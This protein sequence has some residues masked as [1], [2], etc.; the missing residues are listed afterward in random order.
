MIF[1]IMKIRTLPIFSLCVLL[2]IPAALPCPASSASTASLETA[3]TL[4]LKGDVVKAIS[5]FQQLPESEE[6]SYW[7]VRAYLNQGQAEKAVTE[8]QK[9]LENNTG[10]A[11]TCSAMGDVEFRQGHFESATEFYRQ[12]IESGQE[13]ARSYLGLGKIL[14]SEKMLKSAKECFEKAFSLDPE[15]PDII[16]EK[17]RYQK[18]S[19]EEKELWLRYL[20]TAGYEDP[21]YLENLNSWLERRQGLVRNQPPPDQGDPGTRQHQ[22]ASFLY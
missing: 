18:P 9:L 17:A 22:A 13:F 14:E 21:A 2:I 8:A 16:R 11:I 7:L 20:E 5:G 6:A 3:K 1:I 4:F 10:S 15:D 19:P 12:A